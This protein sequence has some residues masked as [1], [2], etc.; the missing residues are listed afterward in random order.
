MALLGKKKKK[1]DKEQEASVSQDEVGEAL[2]NSADVTDNNDSY[3]DDANGEKAL[4][5]QYTSGL[6]P[7]ASSDNEESANE[8]TT[9]EASSDEAEESEEESDED[10]VDDSLMDIFASEEEEDA[11]LS[12]LTFGLEDVDIQSLLAE[13]KNVASR[14]RALV[15]SQK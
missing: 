6:N 4:L 13:A 3:T 7:A 9:E 2:E 14:L 12:A 15:E 10:D 8:G 5:D 1:E 11:D